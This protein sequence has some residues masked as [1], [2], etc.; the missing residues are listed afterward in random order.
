MAGMGHR[1]G[2]DL[3]QSCGS[4]AR[5]AHLR[6]WVVQRVPA[7]LGRAHLVQAEPGNQGRAFSKL[8]RSRS[9]NS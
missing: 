9:F 4:A 5:R 1:A 7:A 3:R 2:T 6:W 8:M